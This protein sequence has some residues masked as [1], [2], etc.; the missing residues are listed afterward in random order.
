MLR[1]CSVFLVFLLAPFSA[2]ADEKSAEAFVNKVKDQ[3]LQVVADASL[4][5]KEKHQRLD[6]LFR[7]YV[8]INWMA[9]QVLGRYKKRATGEQA[10]Q[11][12]G[13]YEDYLVLTYVPKFKRYNGGK[14]VVERVYQVSDGIYGVVTKIEQPNGEPAISVSYNLHKV[15]GAYKIRNII[16]EGV[17]LV[18]TQSDDFSQMIERKGLDFFLSALAKKVEKLKSEAAV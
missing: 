2:F 12:D 4:S 3:V 9:G 10:K 17:S 5:D 18:Q 7:T 1:V 16:G 13:L 11:F 8:D 6:T 14:V 15:G